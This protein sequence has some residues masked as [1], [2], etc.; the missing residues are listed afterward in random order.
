[1][2]QELIIGTRVRR[3]EHRLGV[4]VAFG[5]AKTYSSKSTGVTRVCG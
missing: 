4:I 1:M 3:T 2:I 5:R